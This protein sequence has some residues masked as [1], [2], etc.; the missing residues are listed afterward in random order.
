MPRSAHWGA[1]SLINSSLKA[2][3]A[4]RNSSPLMEWEM[5]TQDVK[6]R[7]VDTWYELS[8]CFKCDTK[9]Q[10]L[11]GLVASEMTKKTMSLCLMDLVQGLDMPSGFADLQRVEPYWNRW[12]GGCKMNSF[13]QV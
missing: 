3:R 10:I 6:S 4:G 7:T 12:A 9:R 5:M 13:L 1:I 2:S 8:L 11:Q